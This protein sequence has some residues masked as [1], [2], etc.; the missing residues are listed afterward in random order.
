M[1]TITINVVIIIVV[2]NILDASR[3]SSVT[4]TTKVMKERKQAITGK[5]F[6]ATTSIVLI[7]ALLKTAVM[8]N[9]T[10]ART[11]WPAHP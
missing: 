5:C 9:Y 10:P 1:I 8:T 2:I 6:L 3:V 7:T 4:I 11:F